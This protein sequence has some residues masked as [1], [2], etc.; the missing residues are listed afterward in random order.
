M[1]KVLMTRRT[2]L[3]AQLVL[4]PLALLALPACPY[5]YY[6]DDDDNGG[7]DDDAVGCEDDE[8]LSGGQ[9]EG[10]F[11][12][13]FRFTVSGADVEE[14]GPDGAW[15]V[16]GGMPDPYAYITWNDDAF[17]ITSAV[18][19]T[20]SPSWNVSETQVLESGGTLCAGIVDED[21]SD[22]DPIDGS[23]WEG[24]DSIVSLVRTGNLSGWL[25]NGYASLDWRVDPNF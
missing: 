16:G 24:N 6:G 9:C 25:Y 12:R 10:V 3:P 18:D 23:C 22:S 15:D 4:L 11:G 1:S 7:D 2:S 8:F 17:L 19:D 20:L 14:T 5:P 13:S 21:L